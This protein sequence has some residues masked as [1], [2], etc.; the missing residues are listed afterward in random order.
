MYN[1]SATQWVAEGLVYKESYVF[2]VAA[3]N[4]MGFSDYSINSSAM[5]FSSPWLAGKLQ[6]LLQC[7]YDI[8]L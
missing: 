4:R 7:H 1:G 6:Q 5:T 8:I 2:R 3:G